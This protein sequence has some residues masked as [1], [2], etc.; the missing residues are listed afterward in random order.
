MQ[1]QKVKITKSVVAAAKPGAREFIVWDTAL[2]GFGLRVRPSGATS[3]VFVY[4]L[5]GG[6]AGKV[7]KATIT[8]STPDQ[9]RAKAKALAAVHHGGGDPAEQKA[10][11]RRKA[12]EPTVAEVLDRF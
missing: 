4:R 1:N 3:Y 12:A 6:R 10:A 11:A 9:A 7:R 5:P 8:A 2:P